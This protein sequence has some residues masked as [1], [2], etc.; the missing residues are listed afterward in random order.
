MCIDRMKKTITIF[1][2]MLLAL[3]LNAPLNAQSISVMSFNLGGNSDGKNWN[4]RKNAV[5]GMTVSESPDLIGLQSCPVATGKELEKSMPGYSCVDTGR[6][7]PSDNL[8]FIRTENSSVL[9]SGFF[10]LS[11]KPENPTAM[12]SCGTQSCNAV[13][14]VIQLKN[15]K[16]VFA[17]NT[18]F[19]AESA[20]A[21]MLQVKLLVEKISSL[22]EGRP[23]ILTGTLN[24]KPSLWSDKEYG[25]GYVLKT[26]RIL[27]ARQMA[28][29]TDS[30]P[31]VRAEGVKS[32]IADYIFYSVDGLSANQFRTIAETEPLSDHNPIRANLLFK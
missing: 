30:K 14:A 17:V 19:D 12:F 10:S 13:W 32:K 20:E 26:A 2:A 28:L 7:S 16:E 18:C 5:A 24:C 9:K 11:D 31:S 1:A 23:C 29:G 21:R 8:I 3:A 6:R 22:S 27:D 4:A 15:G 25:P